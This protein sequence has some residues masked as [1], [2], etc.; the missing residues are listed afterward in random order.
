MRKFLVAGIMSL[1]LLVPF[2]T[3]AAIAVSDTGLKTTADQAN[4]DTTDAVGGN[5]SVFIGKFIITPILGIVGV[6]F[7]VLML[8]AGLLWMTAAGGS[9]AIKKAK[10]ILVNS[11]IGLVIVAASY[12]I[13]EAIFSA[14]IN[15]SI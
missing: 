15:G 5:I 9:E 1:A 12:A 6:V 14:L 10:G 4:F 2:V 7:L 13:T 8:Y 11:V 3:H